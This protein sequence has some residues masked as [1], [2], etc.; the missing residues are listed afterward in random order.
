MV[1]DAGIASCIE[2][3]TGKA[4]WRER[5][6][7]SFSASPILAAGRV[8]FLSQEG[9]ATVVEAGRS[10]KVLAES[11]LDDGFMASPAVAGKALFLRTRSHLYRIEG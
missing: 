9:K 11:Q 2:A 5:I 7:G 6:G 4:V 3:R 8:Y 1:N 10:F